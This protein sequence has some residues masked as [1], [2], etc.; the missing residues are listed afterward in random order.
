M[1]PAWL[2]PRLGLGGLG[3][4]GA[5]VTVLGTWSALGVG[6]GTDATGVAA[7]NQIEDA[8]CRRAT[9]CGISLQP[10][11]S[12][13]GDA[14]DACIRFY[15]TACLHGLEV[16]DPGPVVVGQCVAAINDGGCG[17]VV[18]PQTSSACAWL[19]PASEATDAADASDGSDGSVEAQNVGEEG[20]AGADSPD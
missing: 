2:G 14:V 13:S 4:L 15:D 5:L 7:C 8:R 11:Y 20:D 1:A 6:C 12:T 16:S 19:V 18:S 9:A 10:P 3:G 17:V